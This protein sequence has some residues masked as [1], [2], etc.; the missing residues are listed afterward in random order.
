[1]IELIKRKLRSKCNLKCKERKKKDCEI[2]LCKSREKL[3]SENMI[4]E[5]QKREKI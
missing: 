5:T 2:E 1:M 4:E 3:N